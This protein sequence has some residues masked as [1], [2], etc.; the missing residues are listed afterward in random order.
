MRGIAA[1]QIS[2][3]CQS[4]DSHSNIAKLGH[5]VESGQVTHPLENKS[6]AQTGGVYGPLADDVYDLPPGLVSRERQ[7]KEHFVS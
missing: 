7:Q 1:L 5:G 2:H 4:L 3:R 6:M